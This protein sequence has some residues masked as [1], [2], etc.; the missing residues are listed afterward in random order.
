MTVNSNLLL[1]VHWRHMEE[2]K[3]SKKRAY[4]IFFDKLMGIRLDPGQTKN[5]VPTTRFPCNS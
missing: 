5:W 3:P 1:L 2:Y 4:N